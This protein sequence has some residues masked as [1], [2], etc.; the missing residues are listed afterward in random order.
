M[1]EL[2]LAIAVLC[3][4]VA[5]MIY[6]VNKTIQAMKELRN[7]WKNCKQAEEKLENTLKEFYKNR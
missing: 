3:F 5:I 4:L 1:K 7:M 6:C 2:C